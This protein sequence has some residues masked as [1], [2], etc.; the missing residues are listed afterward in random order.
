MRITVSSY[1]KSSMTFQS[2]LEMAERASVVPNI[3][4]TT[5]ERAS[6]GEHPEQVVLVIVTFIIPLG[7]VIICMLYVLIL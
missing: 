4:N 7:A 5:H 2:Q 6:G 1:D 3:D